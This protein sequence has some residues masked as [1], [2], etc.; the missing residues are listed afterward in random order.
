MIHTSTMTML[1]NYVLVLPDPQLETYQIKGKELG[2]YSPDF[3]YEK[4]K[5]I[6]TKEKNMS[7]FGTVYG[8]PSFLTYNLKKI[9]KLSN[10]NT[11]SVKRNGEMVPIN[12]GIHRQIGELTRNSVQFDVDIE[13]QKGD[14]VNF[15]YLAHK[16]AKD[17]KM[18]V[19][20]ELGE[21]YLIKYDMLFMVVDA[22]FKPKRMLNGY[23]LVEPEEIEVK[24]EGAQEF[25]EHTGGLVT[26]APK[27]RLK[28]TRKTQIGKVVLAGSYC[29]GYLQQP[30]KK[31][32]L[33]HLDK[34][35]VIM[36]DPRMCQKL[37]YDI[38]QIV[39]DKLLHLV[40]R[41]DIKYEFDEEFDFS[42]LG[43]RRKE[44]V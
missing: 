5:K 25:I 36:Y 40:Q 29:R 38:H 1:S 6:T 32:Y 34:G 39:S 26:L 33:Q 37:E 20:T 42:K 41:K 30:D 43:K 24:K 2:L 44:N 9:I 28:K 13:I 22:N 27:Q 15:S 23:V 12:I 3:K 31:D 11:L 7:V 17:D 18:I 16:K 10:E 19:D 35:H 14:R 21:M 4:G 8:V